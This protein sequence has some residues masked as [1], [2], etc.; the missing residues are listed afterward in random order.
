V[1]RACKT[2][3]SSGVP[4]FA[5]VSTGF[6][7]QARSTARALG[8]DDIWISEYPGVIP[9]DTRAQLEEKVLQTIV[10]D[11]VEGF[12]TQVTQ[13]AEVAAEPGPQDIVFT[14]SLDE[15]QDH[16]DSR[17]WSDGL[18]IVPP[19]LSR[20]RGFLSFTDR[21]PDE[22]LGVL[23]PALRE[24]TVWSVA[25]NGVM[26]GCRPEYF[27]IL[28]AAV[29]AIC[30]PDFRLEDA[31]STP[32]WEPLVIISGVIARQLGFNTLGGLMRVG[33]RANSSIGRF[34]RLYFRNGA[35]FRT[36]PG[37]TDKGSIGST[38]NVAVAEDEAAVSALGWPPFRVD[39]GF[40]VG[41]N[42]VTVQSVVAISPPMY[43]GG[44]TPEE[45]MEFV[46]YLMAGACGPWAYTGLWYG[47]YH[48][49]LLLSPSVA[50]ELRQFGWGK[51]T[52]RQHLF[53]NMKIE[54]GLLERYP[55]PAAGA[56]DSLKRRV[57]EGLIPSLY[58]ESDDPKRLVPLL[59]EVGWTN[60]IVAGDPGRN[61]SKAYI[62]NHEQGPPVSKKVVLPADWEARLPVLRQEETP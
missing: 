60:I 45:Y 57:E 40:A 16:F 35:G 10:P 61:Q 48:P 52:I 41:D 47:R 32:G 11:L 55:L 21:A 9:T 62:N 31:G 2:A 33:P 44:E 7:R 59:R 49:L 23:P 39:Q 30:D 38:F 18:P 3:E 42:I 54:A 28:L 12:R 1:L 17:L 50:R 5:V 58:A 19:T 24:T 27:P 43:S 13:P 53:D 46:T 56:V 20:V 26:A 4:A 37:S 15:V 14:G 6:L 22:I 25:V 29:E 34:M 51:D 8:I 36:P